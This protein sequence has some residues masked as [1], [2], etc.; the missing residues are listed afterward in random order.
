MGAD[1]GGMVVASVTRGAS[2]TSAETRV[3]IAPRLASVTG[4][5]IALRVDTGVLVALRLAGLTG[6]LVALRIDASVLI[7]LRVDARS[8]IAQRLAGIASYA[9]V[10]CAGVLSNTGVTGVLRQAR[11]IAGAVAGA[12]RSIR[13]TCVPRWVRRRQQADSGSSPQ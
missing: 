11:D 3:L 9:G 6:V 13:L 4:R 10:P 7:A 2:D 8:L 5:L 1:A 12:A